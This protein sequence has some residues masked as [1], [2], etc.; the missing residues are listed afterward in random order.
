MQ[1]AFIIILE[2]A[3]DARWASDLLEASKAEP[4]CLV[5]GYTPAAN[6]LNDQTA[7]GKY[8]NTESQCRQPQRHAFCFLSK[9]HKYLRPETRFTA[10]HPMTE[11]FC[12]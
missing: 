4:V 7:I 12:E 1:A 11:S 2:P 6:D 9:A 10:H 5:D 8:G 3:T